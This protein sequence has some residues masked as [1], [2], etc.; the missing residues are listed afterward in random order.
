MFIML[1]VLWLPFLTDELIVVVGRYGDPL[2]PWGDIMAVAEA[3]C[4]TSSQVGKKLQ[5]DFH[6]SVI[7]VL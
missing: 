5:Y 7:P 6:P 1:L 4:V 3:F 2:N